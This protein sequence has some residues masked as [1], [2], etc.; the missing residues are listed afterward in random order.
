MC[1]QLC[2]RSV[3]D[4]DS[5]VDEFLLGM[6]AEFPS[7]PYSFDKEGLDLFW[8]SHHGTWVWLNGDH[9]L[10]DP[11][12]GDSNNANVLSIERISPLI[13]HCLGW[14]VSYFMTPVISGQEFCRAAPGTSP[15]FFGKLRWKDDALLEGFGLVF[16]DIKQKK[17]L[18]M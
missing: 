16:A 11:F 4:G 14:W 2:K 8:R 6:F 10:F 18:A 17:Q 3:L 13:L 9:Y 7:L 5:Y 15:G 1:E 12:W